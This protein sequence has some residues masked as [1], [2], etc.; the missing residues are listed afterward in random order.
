MK[1][2]NQQIIE[3]LEMLLEEVRTL[4]A[5]AE[6]EHREKEERRDTEKKV[7]RMIDRGEI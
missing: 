3:T 2:Y 4:S 5:I 1:T 6:I 7:R